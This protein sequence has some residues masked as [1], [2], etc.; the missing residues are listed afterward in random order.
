M[1]GGVFLRSNHTSCKA[2]L[3]LS[4]SKA[5]CQHIKVL[6]EGASYRYI[7]LLAP[8]RDLWELTALRSAMPP[9]RASAAAG[10]SRIPYDDDVAH[11][12]RQRGTRRTASQ[13]EASGSEDQPYNDTRDRGG[14]KQSNARSSRAISSIRG[15]VE[16]TP[17]ARATRHNPTQSLGSAS[18][19]TPQAVP[20][21]VGRRRPHIRPSLTGAQ[22]EELTIERRAEMVTDVAGD[23]LVKLV[24]AGVEGDGKPRKAN[25]EWRKAWDGL[26]SEYEA[27]GMV[28][29]PVELS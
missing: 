5:Y 22:V 20:H 9:K 11:A 19:A 28:V 2:A 12:S 18:T 21:A 10:P 24:R 23:C 26:Q 6:E 16:M 7:R 1:L 15:D 29:R 27:F 8:W 14:S 13:S 25:N 3:S 4:R 17:R